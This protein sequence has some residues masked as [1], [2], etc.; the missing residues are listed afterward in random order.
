MI[1]VEFLGPIALVLGVLTRLVALGHRRSTWPSPRS[2]STAQNGFFMNFT[3]NQT[4]EGVEFFILI[5]GIG[6]ALTVGGPG[7]IALMKRF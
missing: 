5:V 2:S 7:R 6:L 3:G 1:A 4:G